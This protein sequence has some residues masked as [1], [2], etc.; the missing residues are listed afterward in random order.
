MGCRFGNSVTVG[1]KGCVEGDDKG[2]EAG[3]RDLC[4]CELADAPRSPSQKVGTCSN[5]I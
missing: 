1:I 5:L 4:A 2:D 3:R